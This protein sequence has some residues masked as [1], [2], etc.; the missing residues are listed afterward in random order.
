MKI[1][2]I[3]TFIF[4]TFGAEI[5]A[6]DFTS[7]YPE[8]YTETDDGENVIVIGSSNI[9][10][11]ALV[12]NTNDF[13]YYSFELVQMSRPY[14]EEKP[15]INSKNKLLGYSTENH[16]IIYNYETG[17]SVQIFELDYNLYN[18]EFSND[19]KLLYY[20]D[21]EK[22]VLESY[23]IET[24]ELIES[25]N[26]SL[27]DDGYQL[28]GINRYYEQIVLTKED[29]IAFY[30]IE[31]DSIVLKNKYVPFYRIE[32]FDQGRIFSVNTYDSLLISKTQDLSNEYT[33]KNYFGMYRASISSDMN[34]LYISSDETIYEIKDLKVDSTIYSSNTNK[35][36]FNPHY[37]SPD[38]NISIG[39][40]TY[41]YYCGRYL[42]M[43]IQNINLYIYDWKNKRRQ[44]PIPNTFIMNPAGAV[45]NEDNS[46]I[47]VGGSMTTIIDRQ[48]EFVQFVYNEGIPKLFLDNSS[49]IAYEEEGKLNFYD[50]DSGELEKTLFVNLSG[51]A[52]YHY[53][54]ENRMIVAFNS[55]SVKIY[56]YNN[57]TLDSE[58][59]FDEVGLDSNVKW[60]GDFGLTS[61][62]E[63]II[64]KFDLSDRTLEMNTMKDIPEGF[65][66]YDFSPNGRYVLGMTDKFTVVLY[67]FYYNKY[68]TVS[69]DLD[70]YNQYSS[71][72]Y[73]KIVGN[74]PIM[75]FAFQDS[76][77]QTRELNWIYDFD[78]NT[79]KVSL[80]YPYGIYYNSEYTSQFT[81]TC[82]NR[83]KLTKLRDPV[84]SVNTEQTPQNAIYPNPTSS[85]IYLDKLGVQSFTDLRIYNSF[86]KLVLNIGNIIS[87]EKVD[88]EDLP[89]GVYFLQSDE[90]Q[91]SFV[92]E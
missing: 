75:L 8:S 38:G 1:I 23:S 43:P 90:I 3:I 46:M 89:T 45:F 78:L 4:L 76:P 68:K 14:L 26:I 86:G 30:S 67:D 61:Y 81:M 69:I 6:D 53:S 35:D 22:N 9:S 44:R 85:F 5:I 88:I 92:K 50:V 47:A 16:I 55:D 84:S 59:S 28:R 72:S 63:G 29:S 40:Q 33:Y 65:I 79:S 82:P 54:N 87:T 18:V 25:I 66:N 41:G 74:V 80:F 91:A 20:N 77:I 15:I 37:I 64:N 52:E 31:A 49:L 42:D 19:G 62:S 70:R 36:D 60:D 2:S 32:F 11:L 51:D 34:Y 73:I 21:K 57:W 27:V 12:F 7:F 48:E 39:S 10:E 58:Y 17:D 13:S 83:I 71:I 24:G 56:D